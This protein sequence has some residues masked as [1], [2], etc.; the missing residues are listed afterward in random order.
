M[1]FSLSD[2]QQMLQ[3]SLGRYLREQCPL[4]RVR[5][6][7]DG[8]LDV[9]KTIHAELVELGVTALLVPA[10]YGGLGLGVL[11]AILVQEMLGRHVSPAAF[12]SSALLSVVA[13]RGGGDDAQQAAW[14]PAIASGEMSCALAINELAGA[15]EGAGVVARD[16][17][18]SGKALFVLEYS[19]ATHLIVCDQSA[20]LHMVEC[21]HPGVS[22]REL[23][24]IDTTRS[25]H[26]VVFSKVPA[27]SLSAESTLGASAAQVLSLGRLLLAADSLGAAEA[28]LEQ[29]LAYAKE[30]QQFGRTI[31]SFQ[32]VKHMCAEMAA[33][34]EP[35]RSLL[36]YAAHAADSAAH[37][38]E[39]MA[40]LAKSHLAD[41]GQF[42]A[43]TATEVHGGMGFT[44]LLGLHYWFKRLGVNR[45]L[46]GGPERLRE[47][48][49]RVQGWVN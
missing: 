19:T 37:D 3:E 4:Q 9:A 8:D 22:A 13:I 39:L 16:G 38:S 17:T 45:Q 28:M 21:A 6:L 7:A 46:L 48:A 23:S 40:L 14:L 44:D 34:L 35:C 30:R 31:G 32:A 27:H 2:E 29:A 36:W 47:E 15:R 26:E 49:A 1:D 18:L 12:M 43:R 5:D 33:R 42:V 41:V 20:R 24:L 25:A 11:D 10:Q